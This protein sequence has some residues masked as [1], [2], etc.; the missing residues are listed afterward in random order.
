MNKQ[1]LL[2]RHNEYAQL[3]M[4]YFPESIYNGSLDVNKLLYMLGIDPDDE[5][6]EVEEVGNREYPPSDWLLPWIKERILQNRNLNAI[7]VGDT[8]SGKSYSAIS[9]ASQVDP[10]FSADRIAFT[11]KKFLE[12]V[13]SDLRKGSVIIF[14]DAGLG[15]PAREWQ[16]TSSKVF[17]LLFQGFRYK[18]LI[19]LITVPS[20]QFIE[21]QSRML[22]HLYFE[23]TSVQGVM[24]PFRP[25]FPFRGAD[26]MGFKFP[27]QVKDGVLQKITRIKFKL[28]PQKIIDA[29][30]ADKKEYMD[31]KNEG[32]LKEVKY[33]EKLNEI[34]QKQLQEKIEE[35]INGN[36]E[37]D[38]KDNAKE[39]VNELHSQGYSIR[40]IAKI[41]KMPKSTVQRLINRNKGKSNT[42]NTDNEDSSD[43]YEAADGDDIF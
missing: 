38:R 15:I 36:V 19:S 25:F 42:D 31:N 27:T 5:E 8:G 30:E 28:P 1:Y 35:A 7:F 20:Y 39:K 14:D 32:F 17:G 3:L 12:L 16:S 37:A 24:K 29:Y 2:D 41:V 40:E 43:D 23:A 34:K 10:D 26:Q 4:Q 18:N 21:K 6:E 33:A 22:M 9:L 11:T 13:N